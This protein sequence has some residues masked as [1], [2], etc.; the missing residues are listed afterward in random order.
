VHLREDAGMNSYV[1]KAFNHNVLLQQLREVS[2]AASDGDPMS[3]NGDTMP[4]F[5]RE[6]FDTIRDTMGVDQIDV[7]LRKFLLQLEATFPQGNNGSDRERLGKEAHGLVSYS[8]LLGFPDLARLCSD[9]QAAC[10]EGR[11]L[12]P[13]LQQATMAARNAKEVVRTF[14]R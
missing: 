13:S 12:A 6:A 7:W 11:D 14:L 8:A 2:P 9:L 3:R 1:R 4:G 10:S 5:D